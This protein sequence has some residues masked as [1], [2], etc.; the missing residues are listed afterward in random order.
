MIAQPIQTKQ[1][2]ADGFQ[3]NQLSPRVGTISN[4]QRHF[5]TV[6]YFGFDS[7]DEAHN[8]WRSITT[9]RVCSRAKVREAERFTS[10]PWEVKVWGM[11][12]STLE[13]LIERDRTRTTPKSLPL[14]PVRRDWSMSESYSA[15][16]YEA[17]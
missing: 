4:E 9:K 16:Q 3:W 8:F 6:A 15:L 14:P 10:Q 2:S 11:Q 5:A 17:A 1:L 7:W 12:Q 13:K